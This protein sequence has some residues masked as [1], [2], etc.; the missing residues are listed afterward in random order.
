MKHEKNYYLPV[1]R[2]GFMLYHM[3]MDKIYDPEVF[4]RF[5]EVYPN[6][7]KTGYAT[8]H[9]FGGLWACYQGNQ[10]TENGIYF[11]EHKLEE[12]Y[13]HLDCMEVARLIEAFNHNH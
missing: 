8:R 3:V 7:R 13:S 5:E 11:W 4:L 1:S 12:N 10:G 9:A 2:I 6:L